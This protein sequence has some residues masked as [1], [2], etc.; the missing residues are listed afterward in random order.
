MKNTKAVAERVNP[1]SIKVAV[2]DD[3]DVICGGVREILSTVSQVEFV[4]GFASL[5]EFCSFPSSSQ[6][7]VV[8]LDDTLPQIDVLESVQR[9]QD[10]CADAAIIILGR[11][12]TAWD[13]QALLKRGVLGFIC[14]HEPLRETLTAGIRRVRD[15][16]VHLSPE[17]ALIYSQGDR[18][19]KLSQRLKE[20]LRLVACGRSTQQIAQELGMRPHAVYAARRRLRRAFDAQSDAELVAEAMRRGLLDQE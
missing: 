17:A 12:L 15:G 9:L 10:H 6:T 1:V 18:T 16:K 4:G 14:I 7:Q 3:H 13:I 19:L 8:I 5:R 2:V 20:I 11:K